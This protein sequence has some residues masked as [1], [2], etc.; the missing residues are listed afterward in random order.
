MPRP[1]PSHCLHGHPLSGENVFLARKRGKWFDGR[2]RIY[3]QRRCRECDRAKQTRYRQRNG[4]R[5]AERRVT[6]AKLEKAIQ[7]AE[8][9][10]KAVGETR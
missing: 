6:L 2:A 4:A 8:A 9:R 7:A 10:L 3:W 1:T 5:I